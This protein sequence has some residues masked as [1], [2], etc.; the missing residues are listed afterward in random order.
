MDWAAQ[1]IEMDS[2]QIRRL[3]GRGQGPARSGSGHGPLPGRRWPAS[4]CVLEC[5][6]PG[7]G[8]SVCLLSCGSSHK[9]LFRHKGPTLWPHLTLITS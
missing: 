6:G 5:L 2:S 9:P 4:R 3:G 1:A 8:A 7:E